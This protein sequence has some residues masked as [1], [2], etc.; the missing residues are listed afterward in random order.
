MFGGSICFSSAA[1]SE[2]GCPGSL[3]E[4]GMDGK[5]DGIIPIW[6]EATKSKQ[7]INMASGRLMSQSRIIGVLN[8]KW[9]DCTLGQGNLFSPVL[10]LAPATLR[11]PVL[12][13]LL[14]S[15]VLNHS[16]SR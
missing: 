12:A 13:K 2:E 6:K 5:T 3:E 16:S 9:H 4:E 8:T 7:K 1:A 10:V 15:P 11:L 14:L